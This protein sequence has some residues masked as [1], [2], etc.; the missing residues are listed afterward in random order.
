MRGGGKLC[1]PLVVQDTLDKMIKA[2][3]GN[4]KL[5]GARNYCEVVPVHGVSDCSA[6]GAPFPPGELSHPFLHASAD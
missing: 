6:T 1:C 3:S 4:H 5:K 2:F